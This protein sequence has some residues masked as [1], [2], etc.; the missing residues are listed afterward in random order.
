MSLKGEST[1]V[2]DVCLYHAGG[3]KSI[4]FQLP[5][6]TTEHAVTVVVC[7]LLALAKVVYK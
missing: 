4:T 2:H 3:G 1:F 7:P 6:L 5:A